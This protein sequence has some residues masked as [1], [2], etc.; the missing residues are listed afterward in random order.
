MRLW[1]LI[2]M[3]AL[4]LVG[5]GGTTP[6]APDPG[7]TPVAVVRVLVTVELPPTLSRAERLATR[8]AQPVTPT[9]LPA[10]A[11]PTETPYVGV[12]LGEA[13]GDNDVP[14][15]VQPTAPPVDS[16]GNCAIA[17]D[18][19]FGTSWQDDPNVSRRIGCA[20][21]E[22]FGFAADVQVFEGGV[23]YRRQDTGET[24]GIQPSGT[25]AGRYW[26]TSTPIELIMPPLVP[27]DG[28]RLPSEVFQGLWIS[29]PTLQSALGYARTPQQAADLNIQRVE[30]GT[31]VLDVTIAQVFILLDNGDA[32]GPF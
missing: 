7:V 24:W 22:R 20:L 9:A 6:T 12:F 1:S 26:F 4:A 16:A 21:Q 11:T 14:L 28:L 31:L 23:M 18:P 25:N 17:I 29:E 19:A 32:F 2:V 10:T 3:A 15:M 5:C 30:G 13:R 8:Q 27:P